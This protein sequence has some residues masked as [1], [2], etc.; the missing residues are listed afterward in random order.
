MLVDRIRKNATLVKLLAMALGLMAGV[1]SAMAGEGLS[2]QWVKTY[3]GK[4]GDGGVNVAPDEAKAITVNSA[5]DVFITGGITH[6]LSCPGAAPDCGY[7]YATVKYNSAGVFQWA[8]PY[9]NANGG[10]DIATAITLDSEGDVYVT[11]K[12]N[13]YAESSSSTDYDWATAKYSGAGPITT[14]FYTPNSWTVFGSGTAANADNFD[15]YSGGYSL[16]LQFNGISSQ[17]GRYQRVA[18]T[19]GGTYTLTG[20][21]KNEMTDA[22]KHL[23]CDILGYG[24]PYGEYDDFVSDEYISLDSPGIQLFTNADWTY[25]SE[26]VTVDAFTYFVD[27][28]CFGD[29]TPAGNAWIDELTF[30]G[31]QNS[32]FET[33][34]LHTATSANPPIWETR[35]NSGIEDAPVAIAADSNTNSYVTGRRGNGNSSYDIVTIK[36]NSLGGVAWTQVYNGGNR[37]EAVAL[38]LDSSENPVI[39]GRTRVGSID[40]IYTAKYSAATGAIV[41]AQ[42]YNAG[43]TAIP[44]AM[45]IDAAGNIYVAGYK[46]A[47][48]NS[49]FL[50]LKYNSA[51][52]LQWD[53]TY[54]RGNDQAHALAIDSSGD[55]YVAGIS[56]P[57]GGAADYALVKFQGSDGAQQWARIYD[58]GNANI[59]AAVAVDDTNGYIY[60]AGSA[61]AD[62]GDYDYVVAMYDTDGDPI[63]LVAYDGGNDDVLRG[64]A[65]DSDG[66]VIVTGGNNSDYTTVKYALADV[67]A[68][69]P[70]L[71]MSGLAAAST[72]AAAGDT[73]DVSNTVKNLGTGTAGAFDVDLY[74]VDATLGSEAALSDDFDSTLFPWIQL[75]GGTV[76]VVDSLSDGWVL[77]KS[78]GADPGGGMTTLSSAINDYDYRVYTKRINSNGGLS[79]SYSITDS[80]GGGYDVT[81]NYD[82]GNLELN[83]RDSWD[84]TTLDS[85]LLNGALD[86]DGV[87]DYVSVAA[88]STN[89]DLTPTTGNF[90]IE[91]WFYPDSW[92]ADAD[93]IRKNG[94]YRF[95]RSSTQLCFNYSNRI[96]CRSITAG[97]WY[98]VVGARS[99]GTL[100]LYVNT[101]VT[102]SSVVNGTANSNAL[103]FGRSAASVYFDGRIEQIAFYNTAILGATVTDHY[104]SGRGKDLTGTTGLVAY[105]KLDQTSGDAVDSVGGNTGTL[106]GPTWTG[107]LHDN[108]WY[109]L[110]LSKLSNTLTAKAFDGKANPDSATPLATLTASDSTYSGFTQVNVNGGYPFYTDGVRVNGLNTVNVGADGIYLGTRVLSGLLPS[111][112]DNATTAVDIPL[113]VT[114]G[115]YNLA[116]VADSGG[117]VTESDETNNTLMVT[118]INLLP[119][120]VVSAASGAPAS[121][122]PGDTLSLTSTVQNTKPQPAG[123]SFTQ[124]YYL[125]TDSVI[126]TSDT[127]LGSRTISSLA[128]DS[129]NTGTISVTLPGTEGIYYVG[130]IVDS[131]NSVTE[132]NESNNSFTLGSI[133]ISS[134]SDLK[135]VAIGTV[136]P[137]PTGGASI[138]VD[139]TITNEST[140]ATGAFDFQVYLSTN[141]T[142]DAGDTLMDTVTV[143]GGLAGLATDN[144]S[145]SVNLPFVDSGNYYLILK[146]DTG[147]AVDEFD[148][149]NNVISSAVVAVNEAVLLPTDNYL[150][151]SG[152]AYVNVPHSASLNHT[153]A[154]S[155]EAWVR[156]ADYS[157]DKVIVSKGTNS[158]DTN[159]LFYINTAGKL[160]FAQSCLKFDYNDTYDYVTQYAVETSTS[161]VPTG[162]WV[163]VAVTTDT[164][165][166]YYTFNGY[167][168]FYI[169]GVAAG[170]I[171]SDCN[172]YTINGGDEFDS[173]I[174]NSQPVRIGSS[175]SGNYFQGDLDEVRVWN[176]TRSLGQIQSNKDA[177]IS[178]SSSGLIGYW[179]FNE[180]AGTTAVDS[181]ANHNDGTLTNDPVWVVSIAITGSGGGSSGGGG[182][183]TSPLELLILAMLGLGLLVSSHRLRAMPIA[184]LL[185]L[186][187]NMLISDPVRAD[188]TF[189]FAP[190]A[191]ATQPSYRGNAVFD[192][193]FSCD[194]SFDTYPDVMESVI[195][196][197]KTY[198]HYVILDSAQGFAQEV[199]IKA[200]NSL[201]GLFDAGGA[202]ADTEI[203]GI[204]R[205]NAEDPLNSDNDFTGNGTGNPRSVA[206][207]M[208]LTEGANDAGVAQGYEYSFYYDFLKADTDHKPRIEM[209]LNP[210]SDANTEVKLHFIADMSGV[211]YGDKSTDLSG[212]PLYITNTLIM[213]DPAL[214]D[215]GNFDAVLNAQD[216]Y[217]TA[218]RYTFTPGAGWVGE[219]YDPGTYQYYDGNGLDMDSVDWNVFKN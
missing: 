18:V 88:P 170:V 191:G 196:N 99:G 192:C 139:T 24:Y 105:W 26:T 195:V 149:G 155:I 152:T 203:D 62:S 163:H 112:L 56:T 190:I 118:Y 171:L 159:Y 6:T 89:A 120:L 110:Q 198:W 15:Q 55:L 29:G 32:G 20:W 217:T 13:Q 206:M 78:A 17:Y 219:T 133:L 40:A 175:A 49:D 80:D 96:I 164:A 183:V 122:L 94:L 187:G 93:V 144:R 9:A 151:L 86:F 113:S 125:S 44:T 64:M 138:S 103:E 173:F 131:G 87:N 182:G 74:L 132:S 184:T 216:P 60:M 129:S 160:V 146:V 136:T 7:D 79:N 137:S 158:T 130:A 73:I 210:A 97:N 4:N 34:T 106:N 209:Q 127:L 41:W 10:S 186:T 207:R 208:I 90:S 38:A 199:Y 177:Q 218:G 153:N 204:F 128:G 142:W 114:P 14:T 69:Q 71:I 36:Y 108:V 167:S 83:R 70:D 126:T 91:F 147:G 58:N 176:V 200:N 77:S 172:S 11:G 59:P 194:M 33:V 205:G 54:D 98:H 30:T 25:G 104:N 19:P 5:G 81:L 178:P 84:V 197:G 174:T 143:A 202:L 21:L 134:H 154:W 135:A 124:S 215:K 2:Q 66:N 101:G 121:A 47:S 28:R 63:H 95:F 42:T 37:D 48:G 109:T 65:L 166:S 169:N 35:Y 150:S 85:V 50:L 57:S 12:S 141:A 111:A 165:P 8:M 1:S 168:R 115:R 119:D 189:N 123:S 212:D 46:T 162:A 116:A 188:F 185:L 82:N 72:H 214:Q 117:A 140:V 23:Q 45:K 39:T 92:S 201:G 61:I 31:L 213:S 52:A 43:T 157:T 148:E 22:S 68:S 156:I 102:S 193:G 179:K 145:T 107:G 67:S 76:G 180:G 51:G 75:S 16:K 211:T 3:D 161:T 27:I 53:K 181:T 100:Y